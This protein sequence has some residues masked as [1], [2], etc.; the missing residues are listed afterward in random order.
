V[1]EEPSPGSDLKKRLPLNCST[2]CLEITR[3]S[4]IPL[5][6]YSYVSFTKPKS[7]NSFFWFSLLMPTPVSWTVIYKY[8]GSSSSSIWLH[9]L[10]FKTIS[11]PLYPGASFSDWEMIST[12]ILTCPFKVNFIAFDWRLRRTYWILS[13]SEFIIVLYLSSLMIYRP[14]ELSAFSIFSSFSFSKP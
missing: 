1:K 10:F 5:V 14:S 9:C 12:L 3:P 8:F 4:P 7:L 2:I 11:S 13:W 6:F